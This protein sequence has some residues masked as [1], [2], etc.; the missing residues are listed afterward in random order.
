MLVGILNG[1]ERPRDQRARGKGRE[2]KRDKRK[3]ERATSINVFDVPR[4]SKDGSSHTSKA[5]GLSLKLY[6]DEPSNCAVRKIL[7]N[8]G[9]IR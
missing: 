5:H 4:D 1:A 9:H 6:R 8:A 2:V 3:K 7:F